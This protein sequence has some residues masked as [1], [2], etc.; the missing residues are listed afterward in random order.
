MV[1]CRRVCPRVAPRAGPT[2]SRRAMARERR[3]LLIPP[4]RLA[5]R[6]ALTAPEGHYLTRVLRLAA[7]QGCDVVDGVGHRWGALL[8]ADGT[9]RL[10]QPLTAP[11]DSQPPPAPLLELA[12]ALPRREVDV[13]WRMATELGIDR[14][15]PLLA[16]RGRG[17]ER[18]PL[19]RWR[20]ILRE[21]SEQCERLWLPELAEPVAAAAWL[22]AP[23]PGHTTESPRAR[24]RGGGLEPS[25]ERI[26][27]EIQAQDL[28]LLATSRGDHRPLLPRLLATHTERSPTTATQES[29]AGWCFSAAE[30]S[31]ESRVGQ[32]A[33][34][35]PG[36][37]PAWVRLA[38]GPEGGWSPAEEEGALARGWLAVSAGPTI[39]R[40]TTAAVAAAAWLA[41]WRA[42]LSSSSSLWRSP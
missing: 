38:I 41:G 9:L 21:A 29:V 27:G 4:A 8:A 3:R 18:W 10:E 42:A 25:E 40:T 12:V 37:L 26:G 31:G 16:E 20:A 24:K 39:L 36:R 22:A 2:E 23:G 19:E 5:E 7:G 32:I 14:L 17:R 15:Q 30:T 28:H 6:I 11:L 1:A 35:A 13:V 34:Q 33:A